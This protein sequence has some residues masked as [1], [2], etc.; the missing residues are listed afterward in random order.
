MVTVVAVLLDSENWVR[1]AIFPVIGHL[2][3]DESQRLS[4]P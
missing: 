4:K 2:T 1:V 3:L